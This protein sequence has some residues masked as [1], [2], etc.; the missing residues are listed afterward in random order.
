MNSSEGI[1]E[2][3]V[4]Q[5]LTGTW[6]AALSAAH[7][8]REVVSVVKDFISLWSPTE[9]ASLP[10]DCRPGRIGGAEDVAEMAL[11]F[12]QAQCSFGD[13]VEQRR[14]LERMGTFFAHASSRL[15]Q[16]LSDPGGDS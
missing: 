3:Q 12:S 10:E 15:A 2:R 6:A 8:E 16:V 1:G 11:R 13:N 7:S 4:A 9:I 5:P 14:V